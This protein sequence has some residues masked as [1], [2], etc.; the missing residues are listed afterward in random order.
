MVVDFNL[1]SYH[2]FLSIKAKK[3]HPDV[4]KEKGAESKFKNISEAYEVLEDET[5]RQVY[6]SYGSEAV[7]NMSSGGGGPQGDPFGG[8]GGFSRGGGGFQGFNV[9]ERH[10]YL[11]LVNRF[12]FFIFD[13]LL[14]NR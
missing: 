5:K 1:R 9:S 2:E 14:P 8:F 12:K 11:L 6:D 10:H 7:N 4:N 3:Y 13:L